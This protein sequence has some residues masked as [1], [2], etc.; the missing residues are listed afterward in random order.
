MSTKIK[1]RLAARTEAAGKYDPSAP[2]EGNEDNYGL[3]SN[4]AKPDFR[5]GFDEVSDLGEMGLLLFVADG[6]GGHSAGE[7]ASKIA[8]DTVYEAFSDS[9]IDAETASSHQETVSSSPINQAII[10]VLPIPS[11]SLCCLEYLRIRLSAS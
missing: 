3:I 4:I 6:M 1:Y 11:H 8:V 10:R 7:V 9:K 2:Q 5:L